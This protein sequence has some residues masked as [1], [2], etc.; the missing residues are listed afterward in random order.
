LHKKAGHLSAVFF[1]AEELGG[2]TF[3]LAPPQGR[4]FWFRSVLVIAGFDLG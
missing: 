1:A 2:K 4:R 3:F